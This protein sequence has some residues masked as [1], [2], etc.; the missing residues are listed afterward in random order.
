MKEREAGLDLLRCLALLLVVTFHSFL[1]NGFYSQP[2]TGAAMLLANAVRWMSTGCIGIF[3]MLTGYFKSAEPMSRR[4]YRSLWPVLLGYAIA[5]AVSIPVRHFILGDTQ[6]LSVWI[7]RFFGF[8]GV[9]Y[10]WYVEMFVGLT[11]LSPIVNLALSQLSEKRQFYWLAG[12]MLVLTALPGIFPHNLFPDYWRTIYPLT[13][14]VLGAVI[15]RLQPKLQ[16]WFAICIAVGVSLLLAVVTLLSTGGTISDASTWEFPDLW[17]V[18]VSVFLFLCFYKVTIGKTLQKIFRWIADGVYGGYLISHLLDAQLYQ[19][20]PAFQEPA[21]YW[22][23]FFCITVPIF[24]VSVGIGWLLH[25]TVSFFLRGF[26][27]RK[28]GRTYMLELKR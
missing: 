6:S 16:P 13:Y 11:L 2:Q 4:Y 10:G 5:A 26:R 8:S 23:G 18:L 14:Y 17:I 7:S 25:K 24:I 9:Y 28:S 15:R 21:Q 19:L 12:T 1:Y 22:K 27:C 3:L 20:V